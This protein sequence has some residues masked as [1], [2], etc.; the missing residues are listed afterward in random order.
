MEVERL[1]NTLRINGLEHSEAE[2]IGN[3]ARQDIDEVMETLSQIAIED[4]ANAGMIMGVG[5]F[6]EQLQ[7]IIS[8]GIPHVTTRSGKIDFSTT[9]RQM[10]QDLLKNADTAKDG[11]KYKI[12]PVGVSG[13]K[14]VENKGRFSTLMD[15]QR[16]INKQNITAQQ[17]RKRELAE[18]RKLMFTG[19]RAT[20]SGLM[21]AQQY[22][23]RQGGGQ[24]AAAPR[25]S[26]NAAPSF[27]IASS[28]QNP[29]VDWVLPERPMD[30]QLILMDINRKLEDD[31]HSAI[32]DIVEQYEGLL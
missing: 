18:A 29:A 9:K 23:S 5:E 15:V 20:Y 6:V 25:P 4:A 27:R 22:L 26:T 12:I 24:G 11:S 32:I 13:D 7:V 21:K 19:A 10:L 31:I 8:S 2:E 1:K 30:M 28:K 17:Q 16:D 3:F 14:P